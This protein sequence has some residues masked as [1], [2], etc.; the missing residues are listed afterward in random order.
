[1]EGTFEVSGRPGHSGLAARPGAGID[2]AEL[3]ARFGPILAGWVVPFLLVLY[4]AL[5]GGGY[6]PLVS[7]QVGIVVWWVV[8]LAALVGLLR[9]SGIGAAGWVGLGLIGAFAAWTALGIGWSSSAEQSVAQL[10][11]VATYLGV[12]VLALAQ[13]GS[14]GLRRAA[15]AVATAIG[16]IAALAL[17][18]R[19]HPSWFPTDQ[20]ADFI[21]AA[22]SRLNYPLNYW[23]GLAALIAIGIPLALTAATLARSLA[24]RALAAAAVPAMALTAYYT[25]SRGGA[26]EIAV[27]L[28][29][30][31]ALHPRRLSLLPTLTVSVA[32]SAILI[33]AAN[34]RDALGNGLG[35]ATAHSQGNEMLAITLVVCAGAALLQ[36]AIGLASRHG[37]GPRIAVSRNAAGGAFAIAALAAIVIALAAGL[38]GYLSDRWDDFK[39]PVGAQVTNAERFDSASGN[40]RY[41]YWKAAFHENETDPLIGTGPG[42]F[43][44]WWAEHGS[45]PGFVRNAHSLYFETLGE[46]GIVGLLLIVGFVLWPIA[47][48]I[49]AALRLDVERRALLAGAVAA[50][51]AFATAAGVDWIWQIP[52]IPVAFLLV[53][54]AVLT[55]GAR[56]RRPG[57]GAPLVPRIGLVALGLVA[58]VLIAIP[59][60]STDKV[61]A[62]QAD[63]RAR[64][65]GAALS[66]AR[67]AANVEPYA[68][69]PKLQEALVLELQGNLGP[70]V[71]AA[72]EATNADANN[73]RTWMVL[74]RLEAERGRAGPAVAAYKRARSL[75]PRSQL[76][77][78]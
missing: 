20:T 32:G 15:G 21:G 31:V 33:A 40:G 19:V 58:L 64:D 7:D 77:N 78:G 12:F 1:M 52:A 18:S 76:F 47:V 34:Q 39:N 37:L 22:R 5:K 2:V 75:D 27:A 24:L 16:V 65:L 17:L 9:L 68:A 35:T 57:E 50:C 62:S 66:A 73:W 11:L 71:S 55:V 10:A 8:V 44:N 38:P 70:A 36:V 59:L 42:T 69:T 4:L 23:N 67:T 53:A 13:R 51:A 30:L 26:L 3:A 72:T 60:A 48:G 25:Y 43:Q 29:A 6:D 61:R 45:I 41:Q 74:S 14:E 54:G 49:R 46:L 28:V 63:V 56:A